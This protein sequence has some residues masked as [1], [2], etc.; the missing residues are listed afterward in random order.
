M[1]PFMIPQQNE[2]LMLQ[3]IRKH[4]NIYFVDEIFPVCVTVAQLTLDQFVEVR[5]LDRE[6]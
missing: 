5:I 4:D 1:A 2:K 3:N 6:P